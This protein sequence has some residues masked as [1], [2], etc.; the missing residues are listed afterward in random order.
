M[1]ENP[2]FWEFCIN[3]TYSFIGG[4]IGSAIT[5]YWMDRKIRKA[6]EKM[7]VLTA[8]FVN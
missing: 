4:L 2:E 1:L 8:H 5:S 7:K 6:E 3:F